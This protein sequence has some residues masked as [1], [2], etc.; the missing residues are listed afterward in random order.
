MLDIHK[1]LPKAN[2]SSPVVIKKKVLD[3]KIAKGFPDIFTKPKSQLS[4]KGRLRYPS[5]KYGDT[6]KVK[7]NQSVESKDSEQTIVI[8]NRLYKRIKEET[9]KI[10]ESRKIRLPRIQRV[11]THKHHNHSINYSVRSLSGNRI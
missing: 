2:Y 10:N 4:H 5:E 7:H 9:P 11:A 1:R 3:I 6:P 8:R